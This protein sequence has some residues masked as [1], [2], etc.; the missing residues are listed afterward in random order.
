MTEAASDKE[1]ERLTAL[2]EYHILGS[3]TEFAYDEIAELAAQ[4]CQC[5]AAVINF[6]DDKSVWS[7]CRYGLP[8]KKPTPR[9]LS[10]CATTARG[11]DLL[12][13]PDM[14]KDERSEQHPGVTGKPYFRFYCGMPLINP[15]GFSLGT[16]CVLDFQPREISF[17][18]GEAV[19]RLARQ[20]VTLLELRRSLLQLNRTRQELQDQREKSERL[21][22]NMLPVAVAQELKDG[23]RVTA[24]F[25]DAATILFADFE[26]FTKLAESMEPKELIGQLDDYFSAFDEIAERHRLEMLKTIGDA[27]M[28]V[29]GVPETNRSHSI[30]ACLAALKM[31]QLIA[32]MNRERKKLRLPHWDLRVGLHTGPVIAGVVGRRKFIYDVW[33]D[34][35]NVAARME[36]AGAAG[37]INVSEAI[38][39]R[40]K[41]LFDFEPRGSV[42]A[43]NKGRLEMFF[44]LRIKASFARDGEGYAPNEAFFAAAGTPFPILG[45]A[46]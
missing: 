17:E 44:L 7:K 43:K 25:Y 35:V 12:V 26:G 8:P 22:H 45:S 9:E 18:Q 21:L 40:T 1:T 33:G 31:Q 46:A 10:L 13:I 28:C 42:E 24:R 29:G 15:E 19:R 20:V 38:Y 3:P 34:A 27:Y 37:K 41:D 30:D 2:R 11:S 23:H 14:T 36:S 16:L 39:H 32:G 5:P 4:V 6:L